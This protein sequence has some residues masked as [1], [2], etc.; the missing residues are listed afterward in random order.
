MVALEALAMYATKTFRKDGPDLRVS[1][2][3]TGFR[4]RIRINNANR[5]LLQTLDLP[6]IPGSYTVQTQ[7]R[8]CLFMQVRWGKGLPNGLWVWSEAEQMGGNFL[9]RTLRSGCLRWDPIMGYLS[10]I[11]SWWP[12]LQEA[13]LTMPDTMG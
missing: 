9:P 5:L 3:S 10:F 11:R 12:A 4:H 8:G 13:S 2:S 7:G 6:A 1:I